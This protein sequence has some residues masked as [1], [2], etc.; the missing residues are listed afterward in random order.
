VADEQGHGEARDRVAPPE[1]GRDRGQAGQRATSHVGLGIAGAALGIAGNQAV[2]RYKLSTG[3]QIN[4]A[5]LIADAR[6]SWLDALS[7]A[8]APCPVSLRTLSYPANAALAQMTTAIPIPARSSA[9][10]R[11]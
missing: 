5:T 8:G 3:K 9:R 7:S 1:T 10:S 2:A 6:H 11:P 4:S